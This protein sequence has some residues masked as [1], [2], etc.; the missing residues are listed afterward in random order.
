MVDDGGAEGARVLREAGT[1]V[2]FG[3]TFPSF[4]D[5]RARLH[6]PDSEL[7]VPA[8]QPLDRAGFPLALLS[9]ATN[10]TIN[11]ML[12]EVHPAEAV[13]AV[14]PADAAARG[15]ST[16][17]RSGSGTSQASLVVPCRVDGSLR[18]GVVVL[19]KGLWRRHV[20]GGLTANALVPDTVNDLAGGA[21]FN[22]ARVEVDAVAEAG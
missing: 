2:Q 16:G 8:F 20:P 4:D 18:P 6:Q 15:S 9:P 10:R 21:C 12:G 11:S 22:D 14:S 17:G 7:P 13:L 19:P 1:T 5:R 3:T